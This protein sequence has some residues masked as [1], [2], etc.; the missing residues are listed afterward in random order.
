[1]TP[2][3]VQAAAMLFWPLALGTLL[4]PPRFAVL[5]LLLLG[6]VDPS[7]GGFSSATSIGIANLAKGTALPAILIARLRPSTVLPRRWPLALWL[8]FALCVYCAFAIVISENRLAGVK[9]TVYLLDYALL[10]VIL[11]ESWRRGILRPR[12]VQ[13]AVWAAFAFAVVQT[14][15]LGNSYGTIEGRFTSFCAP[16]AFAAFMLPAFAILTLCAPWTP[17]NLLSALLA[18]IGLVLAGSRYVFLG[19]VMFVLVASTAYVMSGARA[20]TRLRRFVTSIG[21]LA[22]SV[23]SLVSLAAVLSVGRLTGFANSDVTARTTGV[24]AAGGTF[25][26]RLG[27]YAMALDQ[28]LHRAPAQQIV[29]FG[30][31]TGA[32]LYRENFQN[33]DEEAFD[34]NRIVHNEFLRAWYEW[35]AIGLMLLVAIIMTVGV[36]LV[37][38]YRRVRSN[39][40]LVGLAT[41]PTIVLGLGIENVLSGAMVANGMGFT[42]ALAAAWA[43]E[44]QRRELVAA[45]RASPGRPTIDRAAA[46]GLSTTQV[47]H[48]DA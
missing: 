14:Y 15:V 39:Y 11:A 25:V 37:R 9:M 4:L 29:G 10:F 17:F 38:Q 27:V 2:L 26:W 16:Q 19:M 20:Q 24:G 8:W 46:T 34:A 47:F 36:F 23:I 45:Q 31:S 1:M 21:L 6:H 28:I 44:L 40:L 22:L 13:M 35:G 33:V 48:V 7:G 30:T 3:A 43:V 12:E 18:V 32:R 41:L 5:C 42:C